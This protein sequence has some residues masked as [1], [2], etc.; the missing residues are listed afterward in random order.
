MSPPGAVYSIHSRLCIIRQSYITLTGMPPLTRPLFK[1]MTP[2]TIPPLMGMLPLTRLLADAHPLGAVNI[3]QSV[4]HHAVGTKISDTLFVQ[5]SPVV[6]NTHLP[7]ITYPDAGNTPL[8]VLP[9]AQHGGCRSLRA[10]ALLQ[11]Q[12]KLLKITI[13]IQWGFNKMDHLPGLL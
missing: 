3:H 6:G 12:V 7:T 1:G 2:L 9:V 5:S 13:K 10:A 8:F 11:T 4:P